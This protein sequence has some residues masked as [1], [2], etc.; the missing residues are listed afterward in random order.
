LKPLADAPETLAELVTAG[1]L[2]IATDFDGWYV[3]DYLDHNA[4]AAEVKAAREANARR[5]AKHREKRKAESVCNSLPDGSQPLLT[6][7]VAAR[8]AMAANDGDNTAVV[9]IAE[10][11][12]FESIGAEWWFELTTRRDDFTSWRS[13]YAA[14]GAKPAHERAAV[15]KHWRET[16]YINERPDPTQPSQTFF[17]D[18]AIKFWE[19]FKVGPRILTAKPLAWARPAPGMPTAKADIETAAETNPEWIEGAAQ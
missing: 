11:R 18:H 6:P 17:P 3:H 12:S 1:F 7:N 2:E 13:A 14:I 19:A 10:R 9:N 5:V 8:A 4:S 16:P 15:A